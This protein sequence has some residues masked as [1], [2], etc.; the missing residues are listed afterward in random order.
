M[1]LAQSGV[2]LKTPAGAHGL[3][4]IAVVNKLW[5]Q[6]SFLKKLLE[7]WE[8]AMNS[9]VSMEHT[10]GVCPVFIPQYQVDVNPGRIRVER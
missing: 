7:D 9:Q 3:V 8:R 1:R 4:R 6:F 5:L 10:N 2:G